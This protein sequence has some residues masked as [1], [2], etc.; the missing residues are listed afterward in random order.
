MNWRRA[1]SFRK[2]LG[3]PR[4]AVEDAPT[5]ADALTRSEQG[6]DFADALHLSSATHA[7][8]FA[9]LDARLKRR[10]RKQDHVRLP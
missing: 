5:V 7:G 2:T 9:T 4:V 10:A 8:D 6:P 3:L 1:T